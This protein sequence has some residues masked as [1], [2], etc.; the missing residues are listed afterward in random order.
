VTFIHKHWG[1]IALALIGGAV[2]WVYRKGAVSGPTAESAARF[3]STA[4][5]RN[6][7][8]PS[9]GLGFAAL[10]SGMIG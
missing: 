5:P 8:V 6:E 7:Q 2:F 9:S 4:R 10:R 3:A 1:W